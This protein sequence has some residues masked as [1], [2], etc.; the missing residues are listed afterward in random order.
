MGPGPCEMTIVIY[1]LKGLK[2][3]K[4]FFEKHDVL[5]KLKEEGMDDEYEMLIKELSKTSNV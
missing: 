1:R 5:H 4:I 2:D 3:A